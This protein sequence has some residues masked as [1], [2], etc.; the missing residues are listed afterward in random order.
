MKT[1][2]VLL[3]GINVSGKNKL[4]MKELREMLEKL[5]FT[6]I[7]TYI[8]S[9][10]IILQSEATKEEIVESIHNAIKSEFGYDVPII[11]RTP[12]EWKKAI[13]NYPFSIENE[14][15][16]A[17]CFLDRAVSKNEIDIKGIN[18]DQY[19]VYNDVVYLYCPSGFGSTKLTNNSIEK[20]LNVAATTRNLKTTLKLWE[21][22]KEVN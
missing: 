20:K 17:F 16:V 1:Y 7:S 11:I 19:K 13:D 3:R 2:I 21:L 18:E 10:N 5:S 8:Q 12:Q 4:P 14:K 9:G 22:S 15:I 6:N